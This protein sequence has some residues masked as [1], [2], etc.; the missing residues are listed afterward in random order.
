[1]GDRKAHL[2]GRFWPTR[3]QVITVWG[4][5][6]D[7]V[8]QWMDATRELHESCRDVIDLWDIQ[9]KDGEV[10]EAMTRLRHALYQA[11]QWDLEP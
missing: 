4:G 7:M 1:M 11:R 8:A 5:E 6:P 2:A 3:A 10:E 9:A